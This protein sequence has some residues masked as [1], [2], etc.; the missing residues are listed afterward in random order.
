MGFQR[1]LSRKRDLALNEKFSLKERA[2][3]YTGQIHRERTIRHLNMLKQRYHR[4]SPRAPSDGATAKPDPSLQRLQ[5]QINNLQRLNGQDLK[6][7]QICDRVEAAHAKEWANKKDIQIT[8][9]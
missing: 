2:D 4:R 1:D 3:F 9:V 7:Q 8:V 6:G 5:D